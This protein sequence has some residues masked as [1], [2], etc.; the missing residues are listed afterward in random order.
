MQKEWDSLCK[1]CK[2]KLVK[3]TDKSPSAV[4]GYTR[5]KLMN[6][7][8][9]LKTIATIPYQEAIGSLLYAV[10]CTHPN[11]VFT[12]QT[13]SQFL[14][15]LGPKYWT[16]VKSVIRYLKGTVDYGITLG[17]SDINTTRLIGWCN[18]DWACNLDDR[19]LITGFTFFLGIGTM[20]Y[21]S[22]KQ[23]SVALS[24]AEA[25][26]MGTGVAA[27]EALWLRTLLKELG[28]SQQGPT[29]IHNDNQAS[30]SISKDP[31][32]HLHSKHIDI[33]HHFIRE[34]VT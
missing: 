15:N 27:K 10:I 19:K 14:S 20:C 7:M 24:T 3:L 22:K 2:F 28:Y 16:A 29:V 13:L 9:T 17:R 33:Q 1:L 31:A 8:D 11:I 30:I 23:T 18:P 26:Y 12:V 21:S 4:D 25:K 5:S 6:N 32:H 34:C